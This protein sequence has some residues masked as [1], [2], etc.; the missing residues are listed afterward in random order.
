MHFGYFLT[1]TTLTFIFRVL[2]LFIPTLVLG[3]NTEE[4]KNHIV[5]LRTNPFYTCR[6]NSRFKFYLFV[7]HLYFYILNKQILKENKTKK[8]F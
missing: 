8:C 7:N 3:I 5:V 4:V 1:T 2:V 6:I